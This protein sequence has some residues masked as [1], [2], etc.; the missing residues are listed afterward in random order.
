MALCGPIA[1]NSA[2]LGIGTIFLALAGVGCRPRSRL[3]GSD[4]AAALATNAAAKT[5]ATVACTQPAK[6]GDPPPR[7]LRRCFEDV[8]PWVDSPVSVLLDRA[9][10]YLDRSDTDGALACAE[11]AARQAP[12][13]VEAH[14]DRAVALIRLGRFDEARDALAFAL[15]LAPSDPE[16]LELAADF[17]VNHLPPSA[18]RAA[19]GLEYARRGLHNIGRDHGRVG[20]LALLEGQALIDLG[21]AAEALRPLGLALRHMPT[22]SS[23]RYERG[24]ALFELC[25]FDEARRA[26]ERVLEVE[27]DHAHAQFHLGLIHERAG[28]DDS[29]A[30]RFAEASRDD[31]KSFPP[32]P[33][34]SSAEFGARVRRVM[35]SLP[36]D[37]RRDLAGISVDT[38]ELPTL[39]DLTAE[40]PPLSP[41]ILGLFRGLPLGRDDAPDSGTPAVARGGRG[42][43][44]RGSGGA[45]ASGNPASFATP[46]RAIVLYRRNILRSV[47]SVDELDRAI[48][49]TLLHEVGHLRGE[50]DGSLRDRGLE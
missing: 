18:E 34:I 43:K 1:R 6:D 17:Y 19:I 24:V 46:E 29:A 20:H 33:R 49:R 3:P 15:A 8:P 16:T 25:R 40:L 13:S 48:E 26:F 12:R 30:I 31:P 35:A 32:V 36:S 11:E 23:A 22:D 10:D 39:E 9:G 42:R 2:L 47:Q 21:R 5:D 27:P 4:R 45:S 28:E 7:P 37:V 50:D 44:P 38:A 14:H 41:T